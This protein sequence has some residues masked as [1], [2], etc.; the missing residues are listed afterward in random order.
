MKGRTFVKQKT[1]PTVIRNRMVRQ[2]VL[3]ISLLVS[4]SLQA[5][6]EKGGYNRKRQHTGRFCHHPQAKRLQESD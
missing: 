6:S 2:L 4:F 1:F 3:Y 5:Q